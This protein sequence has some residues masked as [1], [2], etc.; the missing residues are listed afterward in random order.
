[1]K[2]TVKCNLKQGVT[3][4]AATAHAKSLTDFFYPNALY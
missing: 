2:L 4:L 3:F 1:M